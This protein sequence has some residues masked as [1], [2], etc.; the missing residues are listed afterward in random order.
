L[1]WAW[2]R[3]FERFDVVLCPIAP[4]VAFKHD[5]SPNQNERKLRIRG[6]DTPYLDQ[7]FWAGI[8]CVAYLPATIAPVGPGRSGLPIG[9]Q[10]V[11]PEFGDLV[12]IEFARLLAREIGGF[13]PPP[14]Y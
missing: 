6:K 7:L 11:G 3:F 9:L 5:H 8:T 14:G 2:H 4:T 10:I 13:T 12:T 1:R